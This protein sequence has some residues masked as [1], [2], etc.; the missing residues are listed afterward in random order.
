MRLCPWSL[1]S[2]IPVLGLKSVCPRKGC[3]WPWPRIYFV[4]LALASSLVSSTPPL[5]DFESRDFSYFE[6]MTFRDQDSRSRLEVQVRG[7]TET[8]LSKMC[9]ETVS[10]TE[11]GLENYITTKNVSSRPRTF[12][13]TPP[14]VF[15]HFFIFGL[16]F[17]LPL[18]LF[19]IAQVG[20][21]LHI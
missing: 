13:K 10:R 7:E 21:W 3:P 4:S 12:S 15:K 11:T 2:S 9:L 19:I 16:N 1:A 20:K 6:T 5:Q 14:L 17:L 18:K 8:R